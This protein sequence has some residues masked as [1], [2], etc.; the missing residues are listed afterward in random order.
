MGAAY[1]QRRR[2]PPWFT[3]LALTVV[4]LLVVAV[5]ALGVMNSRALARQ[6]R[7]STG[8][9]HKPIPA[10]SFAN[11]D[12]L[13]SKLPRDAAVSLSFEVKSPASGGTGTATYQ[14][15]PNAPVQRLLTFTYRAQSQAQAYNVT[16]VTPK[17]SSIV[18][19]WIAAPALQL[20]IYYVATVP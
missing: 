3:T 5:V 9:V 19:V 11:P 16:F 14:P 8:E 7:L 12:Q 4:T 15:G 2:P 10:L 13:V 20:S 18:H 1:A 6:W 17:T